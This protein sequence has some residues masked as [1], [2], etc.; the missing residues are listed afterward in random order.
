MSQK[1]SHGSGE[2]VEAHPENPPWQFN[3]NMG[4]EQNRWLPMR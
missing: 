4:G 1:T 2:I 3:T